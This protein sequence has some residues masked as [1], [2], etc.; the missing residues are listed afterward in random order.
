[1]G[2]LE[3]LRKCG[4]RLVDV[5]DVSSF[6]VPLMASIFLSRSVAAITIPF[7]PRVPC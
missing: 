6:S 2:K 4:R 7:V 5:G 3:Y 1:M